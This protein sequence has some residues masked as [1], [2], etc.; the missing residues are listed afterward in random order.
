MKSEEFYQ[1]LDIISK[2]CKCMYE[3]APLLHKQHPQIPMLYCN[4]FVLDWIT[5]RNYHAEYTK[6]AGITQ[7]SKTG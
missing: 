4:K 6:K 5:E 7:V 2:T 3:A 1:E